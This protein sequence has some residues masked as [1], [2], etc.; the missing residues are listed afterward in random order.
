MSATGVETAELASATPLVVAL[1]DE[2]E[3]MRE[4][5]GTTAD[6]AAVAAS[7]VAATAVDGGA[8]APATSICVKPA[9][10]RYPVSP[11][12]K[13][14]NISDDDDEVDSAPPGCAKFAAIQGV[15]GIFMCADVRSEG[16]VSASV[17]ARSR[18]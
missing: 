11:L 14:G 8:S 3:D 6:A 2:E 5:S 16:E 10:I 1:D 18:A 7:V 9:S 15:S 13:G 4:K 17:V 12:V